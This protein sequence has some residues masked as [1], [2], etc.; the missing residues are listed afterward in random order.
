MSVRPRGGDGTRFGFPGER[1]N[2]YAAV[3]RTYL[4]AK[5]TSNAAGNIAEVSETNPRQPHQ[6]DITCDLRSELPPSPAPSPP[7]A[8]AQTPTPHAPNPLQRRR[9]PR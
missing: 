9:L 8:V 1:R 7:T 2:A 4:R 6:G 5:R 3:Y